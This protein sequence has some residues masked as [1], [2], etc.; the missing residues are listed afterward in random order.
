M[1]ILL[2]NEAVIVAGVHVRYCHLDVPGA[3]VDVISQDEWG[4]NLAK[5]QQ[6]VALIDIG[7]VRRCVRGLPMHRYPRE[8]LVK[9]A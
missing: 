6:D 4:L 2:T 9:L 5:P 1:E 7:D 3:E 8:C